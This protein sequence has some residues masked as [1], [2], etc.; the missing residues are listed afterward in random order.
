SISSLLDHKLWASGP[1]A[2]H[3]PQRPIQ[4]GWEQNQASRSERHHSLRACGKEIS[5]QRRRELAPHGHS[6]RALVAPE[7]EARTG[8]APQPDEER[9][10]EQPEDD[11]HQQP[12]AGSYT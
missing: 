3:L 10:P 12:D 5:T 2:F 9:S 6:C 11:T 8:W 1:R 7:A 4:P